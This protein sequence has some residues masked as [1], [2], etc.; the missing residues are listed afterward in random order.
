MELKLGDVVVMK[1]NHPCG[2]NE[3]E[4]VRVG[5]DIKLKCKKCFRVVM[6]EREVAVKRIKKILDK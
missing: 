5:I 4:I 3:F 6:L 1:K 2:C